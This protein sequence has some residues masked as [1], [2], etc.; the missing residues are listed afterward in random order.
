M[1]TRA[2]SLNRRNFLLSA[3]AVVAAGNITSSCA[4]NT[5]KV[6]FG[7][8]PF[9]DTLIPMLGQV[10]G[11][12]K[13]QGLDVEFKILGWTEVQEALS[14]VARDSID[15]GINNETAVIATNSRNPELV[16]VY[17]FNTFDL[18]FALMARRGG[19]IRPIEAFLHQSSDRADAIRHTAE[20]LKGR[21]VITTAN[22]DMEQGVAAA[23]QRGKLDF[24][25]D[26]KIINLGPDDGLSAF[27]S[28]EGDLYIGGLPQR[29]RAKKAGMIEVLTGLDLG[30]VPINGIVSTKAYVEKNRETIYKLL[31][32][33]FKCVDYINNDIDAGASIIVDILN[34]NS[35]GR[36]TVDDFKAMWNKLESFPPSPKAIANDILS[37]S[38]RNYWRNRWDDTNYYLYNVKH[39]I[40]KPV[41]PNGVFLMQEIQ[42]GLIKFIGG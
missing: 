1:V 14:S 11:W 15:I 41:D 33:W 17:G 22:T 36:F 29:F 21:S 38:G 24:I 5:P 13:E 18:G 4:R 25:R 42:A 32:V 26:I 28:G 27:L 37:P 35:A 9:Q 30:P 6:R 20:Q 34:R 10:K 7:V 19:P 2:K 31:K 16:Y 12:Y 40:P 39:A 3:A 8:S 23:A